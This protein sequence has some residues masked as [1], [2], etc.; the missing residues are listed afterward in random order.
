[1]YRCLDEKQWFTL[2]LEST[3][4]G[5]ENILARKRFPM[6]VRPLH[7]AMLELLE[8]L[9]D[10]VR[11]MKSFQDLAHFLH[12][13]SSKSLPSK[14]WIDNLIRPVILIMMFVRVECGGDFSLHLHTCYKMMLYF[15]AAGYVN[16]AR[17][18]LCYLRTMHRLP[19]VTLEQFLTEK[20][21]LQYQDGHWKG[22][23]TDMIIESTY[24]RHDKGPGGTIGTTTKPRS[25]QIWSNR[26]SSCNNLLRDLNELRGKYPTQKIIHKEEA[27]ARMIADMKNRNA[28]KKTLQLCTYPFD[29]TSH[30]PSAWMNIYTGEISPDTSHFHKPVKIENIQ[31]KQFRDSLPDGFHATLPKKVITM[32]NKKPTSLKCTILS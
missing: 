3:F 7:F 19:G 18:G 31:M 12:T 6:N 4:G 13:C 23:W 24:M 21:V 22:R 2:W 11:E 17:Y 16:Y 28:L 25:V 29:M 20:H 1:M 14:H 10:Y 9:R 32:D 5:A 30:E 15:F 27:V 8:L 26:L